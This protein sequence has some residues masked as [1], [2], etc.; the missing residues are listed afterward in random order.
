VAGARRAGRLHSL[1]K[2]GARVERRS[3]S[4]ISD[5][6]DRLHP[7]PPSAPLGLEELL[8]RLGTTLGIPLAS[9]LEE[10]EAVSLERRI[11]AAA[12][13]EDEGPPLVHNADPGLAQTCYALTRALEPAIV[14]ETGV[15]N[16]VTSSFILQALDLNGVGELHS[17]DLA[18][19]ATDPSL[20]GRLVPTGLRSRWTLHRGA[21]Q[22]VLPGLIARLGAIGLFV[23]D[24]R[25][26]YRNVS[27]ELRTVSPALARPAAV[28][29][30][31]A[32]RHSA[33]QDWAGRAGPT[34]LELVR[35]ADKSGLFGVAL[36][37]E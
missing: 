7:L 10:A 22:D 35:Q 14:V 16:G 6:V 31:D 33:L 25:H 23:H 28:V 11:E 30:D 32:Q 13:A 21:S 34:M 27:R 19:P 26:T 20:V 18:S 37:S 29:V 24:S 15:A 12:T 2:L 8:E 36:L 1:R 17:I 4:L 3:R 5:T 9:F